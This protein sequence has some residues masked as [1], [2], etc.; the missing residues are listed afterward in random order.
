[1]NAKSVEALGKYSIGKGILQRAT[2][3]IAKELESYFT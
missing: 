2:I 3:C 1:M